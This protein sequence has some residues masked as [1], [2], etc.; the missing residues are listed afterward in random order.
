MK[1]SL[2][3]CFRPLYSERIM[4]EVKKGINMGLDNQKPRREE[5]SRETR[6]KCMKI[7]PSVNDKRVSWS[8]KG[9]FLQRSRTSSLFLGSLPTYFHCVCL[10]E[11]RNLPQKSL[12]ENL[13]W[14][15]VS[16]SSISSFKVQSRCCL[17]WVAS[18]FVSTDIMKKR[19]IPVLLF[20][21]WI[22]NQGANWFSDSGLWQAVY[23]FSI[24][25]IVDS[26]CM[27]RLHLSF[28]LLFHHRLKE[29]I[30]MK[31]NRFLFKSER[32]TQEKCRQIRQGVKW[33]LEKRGVRLCQE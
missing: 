27:P 4:K 8:L 20:L 6:R 21:I 10:W 7:K 22:L 31:V 30:Q 3:S 14:Q 12:Q 24:N 29:M 16:S 32:P 5:E 33:N 19:M 25:V 2:P 18:L 26:V 23:L 1:K 17:V 11:E 13:W 15:E 9:E 28:F